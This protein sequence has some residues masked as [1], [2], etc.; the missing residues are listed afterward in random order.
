MTADCR[1]ILPVPDR[2]RVYT[3]AG[4]DGYRAFI[5]QTLACLGYSRAADAEAA[6]VCV[7][8]NADGPALMCRFMRD[9]GA[10][11]S[12][13]PERFAHKGRLKEL[14]L[15]MYGKA[16]NSVPSQWGVLTGVRPTKLV[17]RLWDNGLRPEATPGYLHDRYGVAE[18]LANLLADVAARQRPYVIGQGRDAA[19]YVG[20]PYCA[21]HCLYCSFPSRLIGNEGKGNLQDFVRAVVADARDAYVLCRDMGLRITSVYVGG[22]T[23]TALP[24]ALLARIIDAVRPFAAGGAEWTVEA[25]RPDTATAEKLTLLRQAG[26]TRVSINP[27]TM[28]RHILEKLSRRHGVKDI[29]AMFDTCRALDYDVINMDFIA[30]LPGQT[31]ADMAENMDVVC[32]LRPENVTIH[33]LALKKGAPL[34][35]HSLRD[36]IPAAHLVEA[37][38]NE[39]RRRLAEKEY[40]PYYL[41]RQ[42][43]MAASFANIGYALPGEICAYNIEM[44]EERQTVLGIGPGSATKFIVAGREMKKLYMPKD[45]GQYVAALPERLVRRRSLC[46]SIYEGVDE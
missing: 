43:Y 22:G 15:V 31:E 7:R 17:H 16:F 28:Q 36:E 45:I 18:D 41:Y 40:V 12:F 30:G 1:K 29:Y 33:T 6:D 24:A 13:G 44:M 3:Y 11:R 5:G 38:L 14:L 35:R 9:D 23:P 19:L 37:M 46:A 4:P 20:I 10:E 42:T 26:V 39:V 27:Q 21:S 25:G 2:R 8:I 34:F 32:Q